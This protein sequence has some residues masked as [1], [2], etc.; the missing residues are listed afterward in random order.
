MLSFLRQL[1]RTRL[2]LG[3][4]LLSISVVAVLL[5]A[6][7]TLFPG[8]NFRPRNAVVPPAS[9]ATV[10][11]TSPPSE[12]DGVLSISAPQLAAIERYATATAPICS[13]QITSQ[14]GTDPKL[15]IEPDIAKWCASFAA[16]GPCVSVDAR[17][18]GIWTLINRRKMK[19]RA[20]V[21]RSQE[22]AG[23]T[24]GRTLTPTFWLWFN[25]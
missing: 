4:L 22:K 10:R 24:V 2:Q 19:P 20:L 5:S 17:P 25:L 9:T 12:S 23:G 13:S 21:L 18:A 7:R 11:C 14:V 3:Y 8:A 6:S 1:L 15:G 16:L